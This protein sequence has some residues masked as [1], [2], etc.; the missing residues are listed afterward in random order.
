M[1]TPKSGRPLPRI[2]WLGVALILAAGV[3]LV[4]LEVQLAVSRAPDLKRSGELVAHT[5]H[6]LGSMQAFASAVKD[7]EDDLRGFLIA[8]AASYLDAYHT[9]VNRARILLA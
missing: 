2:V 3:A 6:V 4:V 7:A 5:Y 1:R 8:G 9:D